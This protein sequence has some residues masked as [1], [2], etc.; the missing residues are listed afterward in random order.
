MQFPNEPEPKEKIADGRDPGSAAC[1]GRKETRPQS[2][3]NGFLCPC[4]RKN[5]RWWLIALSSLRE[6]KSAICNGFCGRSLGR[7]QKVACFSEICKALSERWHAA[8]NEQGVWYSAAATNS[9]PTEWEDIPGENCS[10]DNIQSPSS[11]LQRQSLDGACAVALVR[12]HFTRLS[13][14]GHICTL[15]RARG[16]R[17]H[18][19]PKGTM[20][21]PSVFLTTCEGAD[22]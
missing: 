17:E 4:A 12:G 21:W 15:S 8:G 9:P 3:G 5:L 20:G 6:M 13:D 7:K 22:G 10:T 11:I 2:L 18:S 19:R 1:R 16:Q 14:V